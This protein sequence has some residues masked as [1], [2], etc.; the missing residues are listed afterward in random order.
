MKTLEEAMQM[1]G[2]IFLLIQI[3]LI[4]MILILSIQKIILYFG[5]KEIT[6]TGFIRSH[7]TILY[8]GIVGFVWGMFTQLVGFVQAL[9]AI[10]EA[11]DVSSELII[12]GLKNSFINPV[13]G[14]A[15]LLLSALLW[16]ILHAKYT[17]TLK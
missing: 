11:A 2:G 5:K 15:T 12:M 9:N 7:H 16:G 6:R 3:L 13:F 1:M 8:L 17:S 10:I 14:L 4:G